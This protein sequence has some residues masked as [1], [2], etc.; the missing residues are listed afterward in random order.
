MNLVNARGSADCT[1][2]IGRQYLYVS[3]SIDFFDFEEAF[4]SISA[5]SLENGS[6]Y[7]HAAPSISVPP[8]GPN[9]V[10]LEYLA[11]DDQFLYA[12]EL[13]LCDSASVTCLAR[14]HVPLLPAVGCLASV[15]WCSSA[16]F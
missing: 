2:V 7:T 15:F 12:S 16:N 10:S 11:G 9:L 14:I 13:L 4:N 5:I 1:C 6:L 3:S 8:G